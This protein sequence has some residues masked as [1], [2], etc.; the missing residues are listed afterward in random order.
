MISDC[1]TQQAPNQQSI[2]EEEA[3]IRQEREEL[4][5]M[6]ARV[7]RHP[8]LP[9][10]AEHRIFDALND[11]LTDHVY[12][13]EPEILPIAMRI[14]CERHAEKELE[15]EA[16]EQQTQESPSQPAKPADPQADQQAHDTCQ[17]QTEVPAETATISEIEKDSVYSGL[18]STLSS[19][20]RPGI[21]EAI[22]RP[23]EE[24]Y[25]ELCDEI[26][27]DEPEVIAA[28]FPVL[29][30]I[31]EER[32]LTPLIIIAPD[33]ET[34]KELLYGPRPKRPAQE[35]QDTAAADQQ[36]HDAWQML[37]EGMALVLQD[38]TTSPDVHEAISECFTTISHQLALQNEDLQ[39]VPDL[40]R[41]VLPR[42]A[43]ELIKQAEDDD[44]PEGNTPRSLEVP[45]KVCHN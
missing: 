28:L 18:G 13:M 9:T 1:T 32:G 3:T 2:P 16:A 23:L 21:P 44:E 17:A 36:T 33:E 24:H 26:S 27:L 25:R 10:H 22:R 19:L 20:Y 12:L 38:E 29:L 4:G 41:R 7:L 39:L 30:R 45:S 5:A 11:F 8:D 40:V 35:Q 14:S 15:K 42:A 43:R 6:L 34:R 37:A 31:Q